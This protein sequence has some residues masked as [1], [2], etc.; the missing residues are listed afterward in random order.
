MIGVLGGT[1]NPVHYGHLRTAIEL[2]QQFA[3]A[4]LHLIPSANPPHRPAPE[5]AAEMRLAMVQLAVAGCTELLADGR[6]VQR[7][8]PSYTVDTLQQLRQDV[9]DEPLLLFMG[10]DAFAGIQSWYQWP[11]LLLYAHVVVMTR[12]GFSQMPLPSDLAAARIEDLAQLREK[13]AGYLFFQE[14]TQLA[15]SATQ[16]RSLLAAGKSPRFLLPDSVLDYIQQHKLYT[17]AVV[18]V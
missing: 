9:G 4:R 15:I 1:F 12:P 6:E 14:V 17:T 3:L 5:V 11:R 8:G 13:P 16:I 2:Q 18:T 7:S 10:M